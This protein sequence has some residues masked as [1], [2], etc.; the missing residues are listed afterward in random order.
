MK[1]CLLCSKETEDYNFDNKIC[2][3]C[4][5]LIEIYYMEDNK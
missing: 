2:D 1:P 5:R 4:F 3:A